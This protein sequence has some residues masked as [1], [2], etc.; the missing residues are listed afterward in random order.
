MVASERSWLLSATIL[1]S[2][3]RTTSRT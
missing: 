2:C 3:D 1:A